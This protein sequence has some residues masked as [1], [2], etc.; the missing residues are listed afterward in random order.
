MP[1]HTSVVPQGQIMMAWIDLFTCL[2]CPS[3][4]TWQPGLTVGIHYFLMPPH[5]GMG[6][7]IDHIPVLV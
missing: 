2:P 5:D 3:I 4:T 7:S 6:V 1:V